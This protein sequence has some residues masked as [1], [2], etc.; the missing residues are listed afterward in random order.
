[1]KRQPFNS[2]RWPIYVFNS[3]GNTKLS[4]RRSDRQTDCRTDR[5]TDE[6]TD[7]QAGRQTDTHTENEYL[8]KKLKKTQRRDVI[9]L[10]LI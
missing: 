5:Q 3:V 4:V 8:V 1:M 9:N 2:L 6:H 10:A 7:R